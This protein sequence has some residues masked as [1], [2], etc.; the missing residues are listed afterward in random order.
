MTLHCKEDR[1]THEETDE[2]EVIDLCGESQAMTSNHWK[3]KPSK[4]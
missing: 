3:A 2:K 4:N 1:K